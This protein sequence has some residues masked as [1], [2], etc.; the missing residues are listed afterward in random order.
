MGRRLFISG[1][2]NAIVMCNIIGANLSKP[3]TYRSAMQNPPDIWGWRETLSKVIVY[4]QEHTNIGERIN[5][6]ILP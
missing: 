4:I 5:N 1:V 6:N 3:H 2:R